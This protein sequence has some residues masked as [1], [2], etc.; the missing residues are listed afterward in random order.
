MIRRPPRSTLFPYTTLFRSQHQR[1][2]GIASDDHEIGSMRREQLARERADARDELVLAVAAIGK[3][4]VIGDI[5]VVR[6]GPRLR[7]FAKD[8]KPAQAGI[9]DED[10]RGHVTPS[11]SL[12]HM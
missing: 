1:R 8:G 3:E 11:A 6:V 2:G 7:Y 9:E 5:D 12:S 4:G 10:G